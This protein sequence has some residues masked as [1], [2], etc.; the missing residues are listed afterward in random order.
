MAPNNEPPAPDEKGQPPIDRVGRC[1]AILADYAEALRA[2]FG[3]PGMSDEV[4]EEWLRRLVEAGLRDASLDGSIIPPT[5]NSLSGQPSDEIPEQRRNHRSTTGPERWGQRV[6]KAA[7]AAECAGAII[8]AGLFAGTRH[9][10]DHENFGVEDT[11]M[12]PSISRV[13]KPPHKLPKAT[14]AQKQS[15]T[16]ASTGSPACANLAKGAAG[17]MGVF[18]EKPPKD[19]SELLQATKAAI[20]DYKKAHEKTKYMSLPDE[21]SKFAK[22]AHNNN[23]TLSP[24][25]YEEAIKE[26]AQK[27]GVPILFDWDNS[28][29]NGNVPLQSNS[30]L[31][32]EEKNTQEYRQ[33][34]MG[35]WLALAKTPVRIIQEA[36]ISGIFI[37][38]HYSLGIL[39]QT[40]QNGVVTIS[41]TQD[42]PEDTNSTVYHETVHALDFGSKG[43]SSQTTMTCMNIFIDNLNPQ[44]FQYAEKTNRNNW[45]QKGYESLVD[46]EKGQKKE[47]ITARDYGGSDKYEDAACIGEL[48]N[49]KISAK[50]L[51]K[52]FTE[53]YNTGILKAKIA[54]M[55]EITGQ[56]D[57]RYATELIA[58]LRLANFVTALR[59]GP[60]NSGHEK[61]IE[62][63][64]AVVDRLNNVA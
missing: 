34:I 20:I 24:E 2:D 45:M 22:D 48:L 54:A 63:I 58:K 30:P 49:N 10:R 32:P 27:L 35:V 6:L 9:G 7:L 1:E 28:S 60:A 38:K 21:F 12:P 53:G 23:P 18:N 59:G 46:A 16:S 64:V 43:S 8:I 62:Q 50:N 51:G 29:N 44:G 25:S 11:S 47:I 13:I 14:A 17:I 15:F 19:I 61:Q 3:K 33:A 4:R 56:V 55:I 42:F 31:T 40:L 52:L 41:G 26:Y 36:K 5:S 39:G 57:S 37:A